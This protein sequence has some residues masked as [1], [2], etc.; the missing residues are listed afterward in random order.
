VQIYGS[1]LSFAMVSKEKATAFC[2]LKDTIQ[3]SELQ[4]KAGLLALYLLPKLPDGAQQ[5]LAWPQILILGTL[6]P[7]GNEPT[8]W[9]ATPAK[10]LAEPARGAMPQAKN[11][12][13]SPQ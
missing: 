4:P 3:K 11:R 10:G 12:F 9:A 5:A 8:K 7:L 2:M 1:G 6:P 13:P